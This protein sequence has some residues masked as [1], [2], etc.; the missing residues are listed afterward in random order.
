MHTCVV[1]GQTTSRLLGFAALV[2]L[3]D[4][5]GK[6]ASRHTAVLGTC[7]AHRDQVPERFAAAAAAKGEVVWVCENPFPLRPAQ[8]EGWY[9]TVD[10]LIAEAGISAGVLPA[11]AL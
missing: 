6:R 7:A 9:A 10:Q 4:A 5:E 2:N 11:D 1:Y 8:V 3:A